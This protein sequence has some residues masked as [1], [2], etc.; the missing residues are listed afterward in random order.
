A[1][2]SWALERSGSASNDSKRA[3]P[4]AASCA[5]AVAMSEAAIPS[6]FGGAHLAETAPELSSSITA[7]TEEVSLFLTASPPALVSDFAPFA[8]RSTPGAG[9]IG[10]RS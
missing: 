8:A 7:N 10:G 2:L 6:V 1:I 4:F 3:S 9:K 5:A